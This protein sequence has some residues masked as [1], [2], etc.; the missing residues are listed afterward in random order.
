MASF[1]TKAETLAALM[2]HLQQGCLLPQYY[3]S[4]AEWRR[5]QDGVLASLRAAMR[6]AGD[7]FIVRSSAQREDSADKSLAGAFKSVKC[8]PLDNEALSKAVKEVVDSYG[9]PVND[10]DQVLVQP[11][12]RDVIVSGV[13]FTRDISTLAPYFVINFDS[14][15]GSTDTVTAGRT[16]AVRTL[17]KF[18]NFENAPQ[19][20]YLD[21]L[22]A[23]AIE[24][25]GLLGS[26][27]LDIEF[28]VDAR[29][30]VYVLQVRPIV[31]NGK[32]TI[33]DVEV[34]K[35]LRKIYKKVEKL[36]ERHPYL[37]GDD[38]IFGVM[39]DWNPAEM[40]GVKPRPLPLSLYKELITDRTWAYQ[41]SNYGYRNVRSFPL[42]VTFLGI[43]YVDVRVSFNS[44]IPQGVSDELAE[45]L[46]N[47]YLYLL[48]NNP[49]SHDK[50]EFDIIFSC[51]DFT[52]TRRLQA[53]QEHGFTQREGE[54]LLTSLRQ[55]TKKIVEPQDGI[56]KT[57]LLK[58]E[59]LKGR[60]NKVAASKLTN[61]EK[62]FWFVEDCKRYGT[63]PFAGLAR[64]GFI[65]V[66]MLNSLVQVGVISEAEKGM[67]MSSLNTV[68]KRML[69]DQQEMPKEKFLDIYGHLRPGTY[70]I[71]SFRYDEAYEYYF[72]GPV[73]TARESG[74]FAL[75][76]QQAA[77]VDELLRQNGFS[78]S[79]VDLFRF[80]R[81]AI[82]GREYAKFVF[83]KSVSEVLRLVKEIGAQYGF[84]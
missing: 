53:L 73:P 42:I 21:K 71:L 12:L 58:I 54:A 67:F 36:K 62:V 11:F 51:Y 3:F 9:V 61:L 75:R 19:T 24:L 83:T 10:K 18:R 20:S 65:A 46:T 66:Q 79:V 4:V 74:Q 48:K 5:D 22:V 69:K 14:V 15:S 81:E 59:D 29:E 38:T 31:R 35:Y 45:K 8:V 77:A 64:A 50:I 6:G 41:R 82:E 84:S 56:V 37:A 72:D 28:A 1:G 23:V 68:A 2:G 17:I 13:L 16:N 52:I 47:Y 60:Q 49:A 25:E 78:I 57:D 30:R 40:I 55:L 44:F 43:P 70:D 7:S 26:D 76:P 27:S 32:V 63:L 80:L 39:P 33:P 34:E